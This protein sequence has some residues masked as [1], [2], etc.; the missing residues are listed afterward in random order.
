M[1]AEKHPLEMVRLAIDIATVT[2]NTG[3]KITR[4]TE[5]YR[6]MREALTTLTTYLCQT[7]SCAECERLGMENEKLREAIRDLAEVMKERMTKSAYYEMK[8]VLEK[9]AATI[10]AAGGE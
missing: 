5:V 4:D 6:M 2:I 1:T 3:G 10:A 7:Q 8:K 9:H